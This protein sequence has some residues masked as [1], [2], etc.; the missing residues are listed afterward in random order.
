MTRPLYKRQRL[1]NYEGFKRLDQMFEKVET[2]KL[3]PPPGTHPKSTLCKMC[4]TW[5]STRVLY[6][7]R[8]LG[9]TLIDSPMRGTFIAVCQECAD[10]LRRHKVQ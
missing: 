1:S 4:S 2:G 7:S 3:L 5:K 6:P 10:H 8:L 9:V